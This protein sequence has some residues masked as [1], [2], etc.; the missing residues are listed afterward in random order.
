M[1][2]Q[3]FEMKYR[4][5]VKVRLFS[6]LLASRFLNRV[7]SRWSE[8]RINQRLKRIGGFQNWKIEL[9]DDLGLFDKGL[10]EG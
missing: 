9:E 4:F 7:W 6:V 2:V 3:L 1:L 8:R 5:M 10:I